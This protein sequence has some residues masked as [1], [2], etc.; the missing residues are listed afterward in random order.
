[1]NEQIVEIKEN[2]NQENSIET[3][4]IQRTCNRNGSD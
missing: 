1:M 4:I 3:R 2:S